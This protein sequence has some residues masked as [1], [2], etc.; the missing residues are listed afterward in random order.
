MIDI[1]G[2][3]QAASKLSSEKSNNSDLQQVNTAVLSTKAAWDTH[4][5]GVYDLIWTYIH[6][7]F[8]TRTEVDNAIMQSFM[9][10]HNNNKHFGQNSYNNTSGAANDPS[11]LTQIKNETMI[12]EGLFVRAS[13][14]L[15]S[16]GYGL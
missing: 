9:N 13:S 14:D 5:Q 3:S 8:P 16:V 11:K 7:D 6:A 15:Q 4:A 1:Y 10:H 12:P 2:A